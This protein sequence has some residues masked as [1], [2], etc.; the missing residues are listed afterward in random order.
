MTSR[1]HLLDENA[2]R[3][4]NR[5]T[6]MAES[7]SHGVITRHVE[8]HPADIGLVQCR[9]RLDLQRDPSADRRRCGD[10]LVGVPHDLRFGQV[11][12]E[13][14]EHPGHLI[15]IQP[16]ARPAEALHG[17]G[18]DPLGSGRIGALVAAELARVALQPLTLPGCP[19]QG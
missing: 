3:V 17:P 1:H 2:I 16:P 9:G 7:A 19:R 12:S 13:A 6:H 11:D 18:H 4:G 14:S 15:G 5:C 8:D 10:R